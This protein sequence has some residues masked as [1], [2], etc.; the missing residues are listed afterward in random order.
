MLSLNNVILNIPRDVIS[1]YFILNML[2]LDML[3]LTSLD[4][5]SLDRLFLTSLDMLSLDMLF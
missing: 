3:F 1:R 2:S 5:L 4:M